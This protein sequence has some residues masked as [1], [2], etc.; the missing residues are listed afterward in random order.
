MPARWYL[1]GLR[2]TLERAGVPYGYTITVWTSGQLLIGRRGTPHGWLLLA[3][4]GGA[5]L[6]FAALSL[7]A[8]R[9]DGAPRSAPAL[10]AVVAAQLCGIALA[11]G[12]VALIAHAPSGVAWPAGG[13]AATA[14]YLAGMAIALGSGG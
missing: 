12:V 8:P 3:F 13:F 2:A 9:G 7:L 14:A 11:L 1:A 5:V 4:A 6:A 10:G